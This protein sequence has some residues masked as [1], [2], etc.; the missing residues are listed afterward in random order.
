MPEWTVGMSRLDSYCVVKNDMNILHSYRR[1]GTSCQK[2]TF[3]K[4]LIPD[5]SETKSGTDRL[6]LKIT[7][8]GQESGTRQT[9]YVYFYLFLFGT[10]LQ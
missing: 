8:S 5:D 1:L 7:G 3:L 9:Q 10:R 2:A 6:L 4:Y